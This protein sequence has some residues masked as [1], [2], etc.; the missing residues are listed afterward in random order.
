MTE[1]NLEQL[2]SS[3]PPLNS[4]AVTASRRRWDAVAKPLGSLGALEELITRICGVTGTV[5]ISIDKKAVVVFCADNGVVAEGVSQSGQDI[6]AVVAR[7]LARGT[8]SVCAMARVAGARVIPVDVGMAHS[9]DEPGLLQRC[10]R[11]ST[12]NLARERAMSRE[13]AVQ[14]ILTGADLVGE[15][16]QKDYKLLATGEMG[17]GNTTSS[18]A[19]SAALLGLGPEQ[20]V[21]RGAGLSDAG[22]ERKRLAVER[23]LELHRSKLSD[24][25][26]ALSRLGGLDIAA[27]VGVYLGGAALGVPVVMD[28]FISA[29]AALCAVKLCPPVRDYLLPSHISGETGGALLMDALGLEPVLHARMR[30]GEGTGAVALMPLL[31]MAL[32]VQRSAGSFGDIGMEAYEKL[33]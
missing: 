19:L 3:I 16:K 24:P 23:A 2:C 26:E 8:S 9:V 5:E 15:L 4:A 29:A 13:E 6:T 11:R 10:V 18:A 28:G 25:L 20:V 32:A 1:E 30:L 7:S 27:M 33:S 21:G 12:G 31:D 17:I 14:A 22:L